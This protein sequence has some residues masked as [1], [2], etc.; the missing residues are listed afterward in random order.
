[1]DKKNRGYAEEEYTE[2]VYFAEEERDDVNRPVSGPLRIAGRI[3]LVL[4]IV[5]A[6]L[7]V[8]FAA[9]SGY[10]P[11]KFLLSVAA[12]MIAAVI[13]ALPFHL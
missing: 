8:F 12:A 4:H 9:T 10:L 3:A 5:A 11:G 6:M 13:L 2:E 1:M 7:I